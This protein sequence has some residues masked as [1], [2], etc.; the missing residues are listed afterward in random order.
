MSAFQG[1]DARLFSGRSTETLEALACLGAQQGVN[2][3][4]PVEM[5][6]QYIRWLQVEGNS[7]AGKSS[8]VNAGMLPMIRQGA[9]WA[10][11]GFEHWQVLGPMMPGE[12]PLLQLA[13]TL[14]RDLVTDP[15]RR[16][17]SRRYQALQADPQALALHLRAFKAEGRAFL[18]VVDQ[19]EE[20][21]TFADK[22]ERLAFDRQVYHAL[23]DR[24]CPLFLLTTVRIDF[25]EGFEQLPCLSELYNPHCKRYLLKTISQSGLREAIEQPA[26]LAGLDVS[27]V[28]AALLKDAQ[29]EPGALPLVENA[30]R[31]LWEQRQGNR[32]SGAVYVERGGMARFAGQ[33]ADALL[34]RMERRCPVAVRMHWNCYWR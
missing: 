25:L 3:E 11:T 23:L 18:L 10:R 7:G 19:F 26:R 29:D 15:E 1:S 31:V 22:A 27:E 9:L 2:P 16:D 34:A 28:T 33:Q 6:G 12:R 30:L 13:E 21:F 24:D 32:L 20:L 17:I 14:E 4:Q 5:G 8:L